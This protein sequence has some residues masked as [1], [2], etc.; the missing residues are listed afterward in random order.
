MGWPL[1]IALSGAGVALGVLV[2]LAASKM[3]TRQQQLIDS[4][5]EFCANVVEV[6]FKDDVAIART[7]LRRVS[8]AAHRLEILETHRE[9]IVAAGMLAVKCGSLVSAIAGEDP[10]GASIA[11]LRAEISAEYWNVV[12]IVRARLGVAS[13]W[14]RE[15]PLKV[16]TPLHDARATR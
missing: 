11:R 7:A 1:D 10:G 6:L 3:R 8:H 2:G 5:A 12:D 14:A 13:L 4:Y 16:A 15:N 9:S